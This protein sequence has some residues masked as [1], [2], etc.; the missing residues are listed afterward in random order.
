MKLVDLCADPADRLAI[1]IGE[2]EPALRMR[3]IGISLR[4]VLPP[5]DQQGRDPCRIVGVHRPGQIDKSS[6]GTAALYWQ[7][8]HRSRLTFTSMQRRIHHQAPT[9]GAADGMRR[10]MTPSGRI[11]WSSLWQNFH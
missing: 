2:P 8:S 1:P 3:K 4:E 10:L 7:H 5:L 9:T 11:K 6:E